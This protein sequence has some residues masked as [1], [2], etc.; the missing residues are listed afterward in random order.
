MAQHA[1]GHIV[2]NVQKNNVVKEFAEMLL[3]ASNSKNAIKIND[4]M[5]FVLPL[6]QK[7]PQIQHPIQNFPVDVE[8]ITVAQ[9][10]IKDDQVYHS[11]SYS[12]K[13][14]SASFLVQFSEEG[15]VYFGKVEY[16]IKNGDDGFAVVNMFKNLQLNVSEINIVEPE[17]PVLKEFWS[18]RYLSCHFTAVQETQECKYIHCSSIQHRIVFVQSEEPDVDGYVSTVLKSYQHD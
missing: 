17:D 2:K 12:R 9:R 13:K 14:N 11:C 8:G 16:F 15:S 6:Q 18:A 1:K 5:K 4:G 3:N 10:M 7:I